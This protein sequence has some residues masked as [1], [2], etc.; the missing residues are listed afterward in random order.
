MDYLDHSAS[1]AQGF[2]NG[3]LVVVSAQGVAH[4]TIPA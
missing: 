1:S 3:G 2:H 4:Q